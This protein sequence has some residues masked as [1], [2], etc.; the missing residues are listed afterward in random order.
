M[1]QFLALLYV[2]TS[3]LA[4]ANA[5]VDDLLDELRKNIRP[6]VMVM[7]EKKTELEI[8]YRA[9]CV[10]E[11]EEARSA[12]NNLG[13]LFWL[14]ERER[15]ESGAVPPPTTKKI[16]KRCATIRDAWVSQRKQIEDSH[17]GVVESHRQKAIEDLQA[18]ESEF[19]ENDLDSQRLCAWTRETLENVPEYL[20]ALATNSEEEFGLTV[21]GNVALAINGT[22]VAAKHRAMEM[23]DG[24]TQ[25]SSN[26]TK[27]PLGEFIVLTFPTSFRLDRIRI[28]LMKLKSPRDSGRK[29]RF[30]VESSSDGENWDLL[31]DRTQKTDGWVG[32]QDLT[33]SPRPIKAI[34]IKG[35][36]NNRGTYLLVT[37]L[38]AFC[39][40]LSN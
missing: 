21:D 12:G 29:Y 19:G 30:L 34:R 17:Q 37:E 15:S 28:D 13:Q 33:F 18:L 35:T 40:K 9:A 23:I 16:P 5:Q 7:S 20:E 14:L 2:A 39:P 22:K 4:S 8:K 36:Y 26:S 24:I 32:W 6:T 38:E 27:M 10:H 1:K 3:Q 11:V 31:V 25:T